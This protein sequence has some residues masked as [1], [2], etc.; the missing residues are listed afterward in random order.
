M[1]NKL[2]K[3]I[4]KEKHAERRRCDG[5]LPSNPVVVK[6]T[7]GNEYTAK[8]WEHR[9]SGIAKFPWIDIPTNIPVQK[10]REIDYDIN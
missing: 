2:W 3:I 6:D 9:P 4:T 1:K 5:Y 7:F 8:Y 10:W